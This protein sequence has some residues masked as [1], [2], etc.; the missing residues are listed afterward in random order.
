MYTPLAHSPTHIPLHE[1]PCTLPT[2]FYASFPRAWHDSL[3][4]LGHLHILAFRTTPPEAH[5][6][7][8]SVPSLPL[9]YFLC[10]AIS[11]AEVN[12]CALSQTRRPHE[13]NTTSVHAPTTD[14]NPAPHPQWVFVEWLCVVVATLV[15]VL[16]NDTAT[17]TVHRSSYARSTL[18]SR[19]AI[20]KVMAFLGQ[21]SS[22]PPRPFPLLSLERPSLSNQVC[23]CQDPFTSRRNAA[24][25]N[26]SSQA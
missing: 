17:A 2:A 8:L 18:Q 25:L 5:P 16:Q 13:S 22:P 10:V 7:S 24:L 9:F 15:T 26:L 1:H 4:L 19:R 23:G 11:R 20:G 21:R 14:S 6:P 3:P 12:V